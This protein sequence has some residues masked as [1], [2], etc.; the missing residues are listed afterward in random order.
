MR[1]T[2]DRLGHGDELAHIL[3]DGFARC[4]VTGSEHAFAV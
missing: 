1:V 4:N 3:D 2:A